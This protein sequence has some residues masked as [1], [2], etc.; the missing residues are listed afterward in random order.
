MIESRALADAGGGVTMSVALVEL[1]S[2]LEGVEVDP[3]L[4]A[5]PRS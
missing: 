2:Q 1:V 3:A 4:V 5:G